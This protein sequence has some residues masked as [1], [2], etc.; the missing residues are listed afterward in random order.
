MA[1]TAGLIPGVTAW[2][3]LFDNFQTNFSRHPREGGGPSSIST[4]IPAY[5]G[6]TSFVMM[7]SISITNMTAADLAGAQSLLAELS[8]DIPME[9][10]TQRFESVM[11]RDDHAVLMAKDDTGNALGLIHVYV[12]AALEKPVEAYIQSLVVSKDARR[13]GVGAAL[14]RAAEDWAKNRGLKSIALHT[15]IHRADAVSFYTREGYAEITQ[16][17]M[18]RKKL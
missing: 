6:M 5:A 15:Q 14:N 11:T 8:Y 2:R 1:S 12:R 10:L 17:R 18:L 4:W 16:S 9:E 3:W 13:S 7:S